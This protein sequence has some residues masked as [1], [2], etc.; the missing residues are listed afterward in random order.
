MTPTIQQFVALTEPPEALRRIQGKTIVFY[1]QTLTVE[2]HSCNVSA[3][4]SGCK[5][6]TELISTRIDGDQGG[7][8]LVKSIL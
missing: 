7:D 3:H 1:G 8:P 2:T 5:C 6:S 4:V